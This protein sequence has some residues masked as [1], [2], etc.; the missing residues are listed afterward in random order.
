MKKFLS[1]CLV[2]VLSI[3]LVGSTVSAGSKEETNTI[4][5][6]GYE[7]V[8]VYDSSNNLNTQSLNELGLSQ[9][10][11]E[12]KVTSND[13]DEKITFKT[14]ENETRPLYDLK[15]IETGEIVTQ[16]ETKVGVLASSGTY[17]SNGTDSTLSVRAYGT[18]YYIFSGDSS[19]YVELDKVD[20]RYELL[21][22]NA[23]IVSKTHNFQQAG[24]SKVTN[25]AVDQRRTSRPT[26]NSGTDLVRNWGGDPVDH[27]AGVWRYGVEMNATIGRI[28][29]SSTW[30]MQV[31]VYNAA[32]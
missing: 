25:R 11:V 7:I 5:P 6:D 19:Q 14:F 17:S 15:N 12:P 31:L 28:N 20:W 10:S 29:S 18:I 22:S 16:Y 30:T 3:G 1:S 23:R 9:L 26:A 32:T 4:V 2:G 13:T 8:K 21:V 24:A 27:L